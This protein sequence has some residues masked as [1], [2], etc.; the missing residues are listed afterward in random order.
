M[1]QARNTTCVI[2]GDVEATE[3]SY[4]TSDH[5]LD[6]GL[7]ETSVLWKSARPPCSRHSRTVA[8]PP[9]AFRSEI[10]IAAPSAAKRMAVA[11][12]MPLADPMITATLFLKPAHRDTLLFLM[13]YCMSRNGSESSIIQQAMRG[14]AC[15]I[16]RP[17]ARTC[18]HSLEMVQGRNSGIDDET[19]LHR[20]ATKPLRRRRQHVRHFR[21]VS[22]NSNSPPQ[23]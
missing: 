11:R 7:R 21:A 20:I 18:V 23:S 12:P 5:R 9:S 4:Q 16:I 19:L 8:S 3:L 15:K 10:T 6:V 2:E 13:D 22:R 14:V 17:R 1:G